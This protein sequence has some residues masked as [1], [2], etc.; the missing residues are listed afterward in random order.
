MYAFNSPASFADSFIYLQGSL[1]YT[2]PPGAMLAYRESMESLFMYHKVK[3]S[4]LHS[5]QDI[6][7]ILCF[8]LLVFFAYVCVLS[9]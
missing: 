5:T 8:L 7:N 9:V 1:F 4:F 6:M 3:R 2:V